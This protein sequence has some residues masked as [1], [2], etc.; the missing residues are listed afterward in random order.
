MTGWG[1]P[2]FYIVQPG[3][4]LNGIAAR[5]GT[6][7]AILKAYNPGLTD[8]VFANEVIFLPPVNGDVLPGTGRNASP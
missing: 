8:N 5:F 7:A 1:S 6:T 3:D 4:T 2:A